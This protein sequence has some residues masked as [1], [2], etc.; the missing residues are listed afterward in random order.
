MTI[1]N[2]SLP[3][4]MQTFVD[5][6]AKQKGYSTA[7]EYIHHLIRQEQEREEYKRLETMLLDGLDSGELIEVGEQWW[8]NKR[9]GLSQRLNQIK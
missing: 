5:E 2:I 4:S 7:I 9:K 8:E 1:I 6:Q 3:D